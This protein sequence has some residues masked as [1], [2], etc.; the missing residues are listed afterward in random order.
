MNSKLK[1]EVW[2]KGKY[3]AL[4][5]KG[6]LDTEHSGMKLLLKI[7]KEKKNILDLGCGEAT[8]LGLIDGRGKNL[9]GID[10][11]E[12][13][14]QKAKTKH[15]KINFV[16]GRVEKLPFPDA[17]FDF[18]YSAFVFEHLDEPVKVIKEAVRV[19]KMDGNLLIIAPNYGAPNRASPPY[20]KNR[21][22]K[23]I[24]GFIRDFSM[25][26]DLTW[27]KVS[28]MADKDTYQMDWDTTIE[29][30]LG[31]LIPF[32]RQT[33]M[34]IVKYSSSWEEEEK[35]AGIMQKIFRFLGECGIY[36]FKNWGPHLLLL[37]EKC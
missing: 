21:M 14:I 15:P 27:Q 6:S 5:E 7:A 9:T 22:R 19:L 29:P 13:A 33:G 18:V 34:K 26:N 1:K 24:R 32:M 36:P 16:L 35:G 11:S 3:W 30:Y 23:L 4:A 2:E 28:P 12:M 20:T 17:S 37:A 8:R 10:I 31:S 25:S